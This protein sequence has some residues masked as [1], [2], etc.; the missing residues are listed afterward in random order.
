LLKQA[1][2][3]KKAEASWKPYSRLN[4]PDLSQLQLSWLLD[5]SSL[6]QRLIL[7]SGGKF[8]V[9]VISEQWIKPMLSE[10]NLLGMSHNMFA[11]VRHVRLLCKGKPCVFARTVIPYGTLQ[12]P[13][14]RLLMLGNK[15][16]GAVLFSDRSMQRGEI[17]IASIS[18]NNNLYSQAMQGLKQAV[19]H[20]CGRRSVFYLS[21]KPLLVNEI[22]LPAI[23]DLK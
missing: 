2:L 1:S 20:V 7:A 22:F 3:Q 13:V 21:G 15:S 9:E 19:S 5:A 10:R 4:Q 12:G 18:K 6:T 17:E 8:Q 11:R 14:R 23:N 16:L